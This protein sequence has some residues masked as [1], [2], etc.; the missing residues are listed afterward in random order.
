M[1][2]NKIDALHEIAG[3]SLNENAIND[4]KD[5]ISAIGIPLNLF[6]NN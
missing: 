5:L 2:Y 1:G 3:I 6:Y 4:Y